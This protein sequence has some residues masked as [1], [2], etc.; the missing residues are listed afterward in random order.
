MELL[1]E[2]FPGNLKEVRMYPSSVNILYSSHAYPL[3]IAISLTVMKLYSGSS[4]TL[5]NDTK[6]L[7]N[8]EVNCV[9]VSM[10]EA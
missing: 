1:V 5:S 3:C 9:V 7:Y 4:L 2:S 6:S 8:A 10:R